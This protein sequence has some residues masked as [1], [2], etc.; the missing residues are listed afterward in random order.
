MAGCIDSLWILQGAS[1]VRILCMTVVCSAATIGFDA[2]LSRRVR[3]S[4][5]PSS[6]VRQH[7][8]VHLLAIDASK[9]T[10]YSFLFTALAGIARWWLLKLDVGNYQAW[11]NWL[12][13]DMNE[14]M[15]LNLHKHND[16]SCTRLSHNHEFP[17]QIC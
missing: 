5:I 7:L 8:L 16:G 4:C 17:A 2:T 3:T 9:L 13:E 11:M 15:E 6:L 12:A 14:E 10:N 1:I